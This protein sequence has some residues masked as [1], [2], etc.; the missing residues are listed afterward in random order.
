MTITGHHAVGIHEV[1]HAWLGWF[2]KC[3][4]DK[5]GRGEVSRHII[6]CM[7]DVVQQ[8]LICPA[9]SNYYSLKISFRG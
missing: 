2:G 1:S 8:R 3:N 5:G 6:T 9:G 7:V 4:R